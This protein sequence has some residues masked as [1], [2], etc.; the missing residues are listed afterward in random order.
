MTPRPA[1]KVECRR[2][3]ARGHVS[4]ALR[5]LRTASG[6][7]LP[8]SRLAA[9]CRTSVSAE[10]LDR[11][12]TGDELGFALTSACRSCPRRACRLSAAARSPRHF[13]TSTPSVAPLP[14]A[15]MIDIG[16]ASPS[17]HGHAMISTATAFT[18]AWPSR[19]SGPTCPARQAS[20]T[21]MTDDRRNEIPANAI[22]Q[23][24]NRCAAALRVGDHR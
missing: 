22:G 12:A 7:S 10:W 3:A 21:A 17:A 24:L 9:S 14:L 1:I 8:R 11:H 6:C 18:S 13:G 16:V 4:S 5:R 15:T 20:P 19:G 2:W 23:P